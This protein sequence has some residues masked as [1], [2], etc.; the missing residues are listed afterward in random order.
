MSYRV[1]FWVQAV[2]VFAVQMGLAWVV[3]DAV[4]DESGASTIAGFDRQGI[5]VYSAAALLVQRLTLGVVFDAG[6][7]TDVYEGSLSRFLLYPEPYPAMKYAQQ[8]GAL[9]PQLV[10]IAMFGVALAFLFPG[11]QV[12]PSAASIAMGLASCVV[13]NLL[14]WAIAF[15]VHSVAFW[16]DNV[17][18]LL[19]ATRLVSQ[20]LGGMLLPLDAFPAWARPALEVLPFRHLFA[21]PVQTM[22]GRRDVAEWSGNLAQGVLWCGAF[23]LVGVWTWRRG[24]L[25][26]TGAGAG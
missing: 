9:A 19:L 26:Y 2:V 4:F 5:V 11:A 14:W 15:P 13:G 20:L 12:H 25:A 1:D 10:Q 18:S 22:L 7:S 24:R 3:W 8:A 6:M 21:E 23:A 16:A 17:W